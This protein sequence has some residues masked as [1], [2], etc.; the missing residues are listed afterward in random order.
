MI[1]SYMMTKK[2]GCS[3]NWNNLKF[4]S[5]NL[6][7]LIAKW[8]SDHPSHV[9]FMI[10]QLC[11]F[12]YGIPYGQ[13]LVRGFHP[14]QTSSC[15]VFQKPN[16]TLLDADQA[17]C[18]QMLTGWQVGRNSK[19]SRNRV[20]QRKERSTQNSIKDN[21]KEYNMKTTDSDCSGH[22]PSFLTLAFTSVLC[23]L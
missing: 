2:T 22:V 19:G 4:K 12:A 6:M 7:V 23:M 17:V 11:L 20:R 10:Y 15:A 18:C 16:C 13:F 14:P 8:I 5:T 1:Q 3:P 9:Y 21:N